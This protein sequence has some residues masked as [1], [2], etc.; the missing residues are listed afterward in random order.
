[1]TNTDENEIIAVFG[2]VHEALTLVST[3]ADRFTYDA[4]GFAT[5]ALASSSLCDSRSGEMGRLIKVNVTGRTNIAR[6][7]CP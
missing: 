2:P 6:Q 5:T 7:V 4:R 1:M 3:S